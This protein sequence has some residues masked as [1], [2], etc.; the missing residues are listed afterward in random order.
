MANY[1]TIMVDRKDDVVTITFNR[2]HKRNAM[3]P[4]LHDEMVALL[5]ELRFDKNLRVLVLTGA[6][7]SFSAGEDLKEFFYDQNDRMQFERALD[8]ALEW[9]VRILRSF[10]V[11]TV[12]M[13]N[14]W[15]FGGALSIVSGCD[16]A[17]A[18]DEAVFGLSEVNFGHFP[19]GPVTKQISQLL[20]VRDAIYYILTGDT[21]TGKRAAEIGLVTY[22]VPKANLKEEVD[23]LIAK[24]CQK[25]ALAL[26]ACKDCYR[27]SLLIPDFETA[28][29]YSATKSDQLSFLQGG[30]WKDSGIKQFLQGEYRPGLGAFKK[31]D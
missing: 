2:P 13:V 15:C 18:A 30:A 25:D 3:N 9:R 29:S 10:P 7:E 26:R 1:E 19:G 31:N 4:K 24:L 17:I 21:F 16:I 5:T 11:P 14:G 22:S 8:K 12:A 6:G 28:F 20:R 27:D 23:K